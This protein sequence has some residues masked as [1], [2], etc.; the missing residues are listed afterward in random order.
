[1]IKKAEIKYEEHQNAKLQPDLTELFIDMSSS[2]RTL[3]TLAEKNLKEVN[4]SLMEWLFLRIVDSGPD[5]GLP[6]SSIAKQLKVSQ[7]QV[8]SIINKLLPQKFVKQK[9]SRADRRVKTVVLTSRGDRVL[10]FA[11]SAIQS[12]IDEFASR[13]T[14]K[15]LDGFSQFIQRLASHKKS[16]PTSEN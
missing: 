13:F 10:E 8:T 7:P 11:N 3:E 5:D 14:Q 15:Q 9:I 16:K 1:M 4:I 6:M 2:L 12:D